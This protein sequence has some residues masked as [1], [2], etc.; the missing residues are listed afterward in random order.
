MAT[1]L[2][3]LA[4]LGDAERLESDAAEFIPSDSVLSAFAMR[5]L[6]TLRVDAS[7][8]D[9]AASRFDAYGFDAQAAH[10]RRLQGT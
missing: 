5:A 2:E 8:L 1:H 4:A 3:A 10:L 6:G 7:L 9:Q